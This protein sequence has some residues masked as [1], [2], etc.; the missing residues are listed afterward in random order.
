M[1]SHGSL[2]QVQIKTIS[3]KEEDADENET[4]QFDC[5]SCYNQHRRHNENK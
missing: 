1:I 4:K 2:L 3:D 5:W